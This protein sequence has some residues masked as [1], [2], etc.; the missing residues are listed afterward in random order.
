MRKSLT[1][2]STMPGYWSLSS[3]PCLFHPP[4]LSHLCII[5]SIRSL[6]EVAARAPPRVT[7]SVDTPVFSL[8]AAI[9]A[10]CVDVAA[11]LS[12]ET[13]GLTAIVTSRGVA[14]CVARTWT[15]SPLV[16]L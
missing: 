11:V 3:E 7:V 1:Y 15:Q 9:S 12:K 4:H 16:R 10:N 6:G 5:M 8:A 2:S 14:K 13:R